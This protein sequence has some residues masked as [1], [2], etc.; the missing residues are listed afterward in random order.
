MTLP[1]LNDLKPQ[2]RLVYEYLASG[3]SLTNLIAMVNLGVQNLT[4]RIAELRKMGLE[5]LGEWKKDHQERR[6]KSYTMKVEEK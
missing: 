1:D 2:A 3:R 6:Y 4:T 5:I